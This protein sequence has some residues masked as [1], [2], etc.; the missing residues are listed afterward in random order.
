[1]LSRQLI[2]LGPAAVLLRIQSY[3][4]RFHHCPQPCKIRKPCPNRSDRTIGVKAF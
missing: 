3:S 4:R 2:S 1:M